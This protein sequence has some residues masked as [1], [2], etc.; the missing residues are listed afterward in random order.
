ML[1]NLGKPVIVTG[2]QIPV[3]EVRSDGRENMIGALIVA[4]NLDVP[5]VSV[6]FNNK[7]MRGNRVTKIDNSGLEA[8]NSPNMAPLATMDI[9]INGRPISRA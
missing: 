8:F 3:A 1:E 4:G 7:L 2:A 6:L 5:E 9:S